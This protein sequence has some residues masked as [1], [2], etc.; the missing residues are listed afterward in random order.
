MRINSASEVTHANPN[1]L[2]WVVQNYY[3]FFI[4]DF[5]NACTS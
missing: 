2:Q 3:F 1:V 4:F 5:G